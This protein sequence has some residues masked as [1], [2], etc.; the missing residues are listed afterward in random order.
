[1]LRE[2]SLEKLV[3]VEVQKRPAG[4]AGIEFELEIRRLLNY[5]ELLDSYPHQSTFARCPRHE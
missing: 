4:K 1:M 3:L 5:L 2:Y